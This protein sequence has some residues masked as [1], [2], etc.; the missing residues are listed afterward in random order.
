MKGVVVQNSLGK[1]AGINDVILPKKH[2]GRKILIVLLHILIVAGVLL[3]FYLTKWQKFT[4]TFI[5]TNGQEACKASVTINKTL[6]KN[7]IP[8]IDVVEGYTLNSWALENGTNWALA[9]NETSVKIKDNIT[10]KAVLRPNVYNVKFKLPIDGSGEPIGDFYGSQVATNIYIEYDS[11]LKFPTVVRKGYDAIWKNASGTTIS[12]ETVFNELSDQVYTVEWVDH[13]KVNYVLGENGVNDP[14]AYTTLTYNV[15]YDFTNLI[16]IREGYTFIEWEIEGNY[17]LS[18]TWS[19]NEV[20]SIN[21]KAKWEAKVSEVTFISDGELVGAQQI[22][23]DQ[24]EYELLNPSKEGYTFVGWFKDGVLYSNNVKWHDIGGVTLEAK[25]AKTEI[26]VAFS[27]DGKCYDFEA[28]GKAISGLYEGKIVKARFDSYNYDTDQVDYCVVSEV[29][30][31]PQKQITEDGRYITYQFDGWFFDDRSKWENGDIITLDLGIENI[32]LTS[33][34]NIIKYEFK[35]TE[36]FKT[37]I[38]KLKYLTEATIDED[39]TEISKQ[40]SQGNYPS[41]LTKITTSNYEII[42]EVIDGEFIISQVK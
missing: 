18:G 2:I 41:N 5:D 14:N 32:T 36:D 15:A 27:S 10:V 28:T 17:N 25:W 24:E 38:M 12:D 4:V 34:W 33:K 9:G 29:V 21:V 37:N 40:L 16:P 1:P 22:K 6:T 20:A 19:Y 31:D 3:Y 13:T 8:S 39:L 11:I 7:D 42:G 26:D 35:D 30:V 23:Y